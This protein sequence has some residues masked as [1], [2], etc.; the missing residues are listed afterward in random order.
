MVVAVDAGA[1]ILLGSSVLAA[2]GSAVAVAAGAALA[3]Q[4]VL[5]STKQRRSAIN[6]T[7]CLGIHTFNCSDVSW[8]AGLLNGLEDTREDVLFRA[9]ALDLRRLTAGSLDG[10]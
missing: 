10:G 7:I 8:A 4:Y 6:Q 3:P 2:N 1:V 9:N 5:A